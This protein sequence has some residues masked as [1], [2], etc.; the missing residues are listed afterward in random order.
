MKTKL[1]LFA[2]ACL[3]LLAGM[4]NVLSQ[5]DYFQRLKS[6]FQQENLYLFGKFLIRSQWN[7]HGGNG[8]IVWLLE[9]A[10]F[11]AELGMSDEQYERLQETAQDIRNPQKNPELREIYDEINA[12]EQSH[13]DTWQSTNEEIKERYF[14]LQERVFELTTTYTQDRLHANNVANALEMT[15]TEEQKQKIKE[16][17]LAAALSDVSVF[18]PN[19][20]DALGLTDAQKHEMAEIKKRLLSDFEQ[21]LEYLATRK[22]TIQNWINDEMEKKGYRGINFDL[23]DSDTLKQI[24]DGLEQNANEIDTYGKQY[25]E[26]FKTQ[27]FDVLTDEQWLRLQNLIDNPQG[28]VKMMQDKLDKLKAQRENRETWVPGPDSWRP[29]MPLP[30]SYRIQRN[31]QIRFPRPVNQ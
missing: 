7:G 24:R 8:I 19:M 18:P 21:P 3:L 2:L 15:L 28:L 13:G 17:Q 23:I 4:G 30:E 10:N 16:V 9:D 11:R 31:T 27:M 25:A 12:M 26:Q 14:D 5:D 29:G 6:P 22:Q 20:F 1:L